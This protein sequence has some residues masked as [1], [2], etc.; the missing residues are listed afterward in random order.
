MIEEAKSQEELAVP[1]VPEVYESQ[2][3]CFNRHRLVQTCM[4]CTSPQFGPQST[5]SS[6]RGRLSLCVPS[7]TIVKNGM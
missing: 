1:H 6:Q 2:V 4:L 5:G 7:A 3:A